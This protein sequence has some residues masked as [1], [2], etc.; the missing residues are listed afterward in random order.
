MQLILAAGVILVVVVW[1]IFAPAS[2]AA[3]FDRLLALITKMTSQSF[4][5]TAGSP[6][7]LPPEW[8]SD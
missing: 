8:V 5:G 2:L 1:G 4:R 6:C 3:V 7:C